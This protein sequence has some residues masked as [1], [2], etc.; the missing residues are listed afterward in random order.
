MFYFLHTFKEVAS[1]FNLFRYITA[2]AA[3]ASV[4]AFLLCI[5]LGPKVI[6]WL[7]SINAKAH[8][9]R[10]HAESLHEF[11]AHKD[12][13]PTMGG[14]LIVSSVVVAMLLWGNLTNRFVWISLA[15]LVWFGVVGLVDDWIKLRSK[16]SRGLR[17][18]TKMVGQLVM[19]LAMG[20]YLY[21]DPDFDKWIYLPF[22]KEGAIYLGL[23]FLPF[24]ILVLV[25]T[26]NALNLTDGS[27]RP[28][29]F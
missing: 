17:S 15:V 2:R 25:G 18:M 11:Y 29:H 1:F 3:A 12:E 10:E 14:I 21:L 8:N 27:Q 23:F 26:S 4:T 9:K 19:G 5:W 28:L 22:L 24:V 7:K 16:S 6:Q 13:V 20:L